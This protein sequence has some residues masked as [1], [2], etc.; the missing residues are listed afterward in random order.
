MLKE[1]FKPSLSVA[2]EKSNVSYTVKPVCD[3]SGGVK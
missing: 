3:S 2:Q 1:P